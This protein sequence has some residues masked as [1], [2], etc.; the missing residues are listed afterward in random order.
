M[1]SPDTIL[2]QSAQNI[3]LS[4]KNLNK[5][6]EAFGLIECSDR[7]LAIEE[8]GT[9]EA[10]DDF[11]QPVWNRYFF[12]KRSNRLNARITGTL[13][14]AIQLTSDEG[15]EADWTHGKRAKVLIGYCADPSMENAWIFETDGPNAAGYRQ[16]CMAQALHWNSN[17]V[18]NSSWFY[19]LPLD[20]LTNTTAVRELIV[21][22]VHEILRGG[23]VADVLG[24]NAE[25][26]CLPPQA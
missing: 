24:R 5:L 20:R 3:I 6:F 17:D 18:G 1:T 15:E 8:E 13:T 12:V 25:A 4:Q 19:A 9:D 7:S 21:T 11:L 22:P 16:D 2:W 10:E 23:V 14:L 26:L